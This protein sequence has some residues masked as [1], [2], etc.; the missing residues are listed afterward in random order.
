MVFGNSHSKLQTLKTN[1]L[2][3]C[4]QRAVQ[5]FGPNRTRLVIYGPSK[6]ETLIKKPCRD[7]EPKLRHYLSVD[8]NYKLD[9][10]AQTIK[11]KIAENG[12]TR[13]LLCL[14]LYHGRPM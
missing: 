7:A 11:Q 4:F 9:R 6:T 1:D 3:S 14:G 13:S 2:H 8:E 10:A 12:E 5:I